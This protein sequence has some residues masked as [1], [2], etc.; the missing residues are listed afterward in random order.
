MY[1]RRAGTA[2]F[3]KNDVNMA[4][5]K[6]ELTLEQIQVLRRNH[7]DPALWDVMTDYRTMLLIRKKDRSDVRMIPKQ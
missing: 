4:I 3:P 5:K 7:L 2:A 6:K 1:H